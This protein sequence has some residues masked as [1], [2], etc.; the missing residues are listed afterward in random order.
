MLRI[1]C[2]I[3][4]LLLAM[5]CGCGRAEVEVA[6]VSGTVTMGGKPLPEALLRFCPEGGGRSAQGITDKDGNCTLAYTNHQNGARV[7]KTKVL[8]TTGPLEDTSRRK[9]TVPK[10]YNDASELIVDVE[11]KSNVIN[12]DLEAKK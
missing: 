7:G 9:E 11:P 8:I 4:G 3:G 6:P 5:L 2:V 12:F 10:K 1:C